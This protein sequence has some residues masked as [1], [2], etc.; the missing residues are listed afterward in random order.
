MAERLSAGRATI[1][2]HL[3]NAYRKLGARDRAAAAAEMMRR[4]L[5]E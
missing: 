2:T 1:K 5:I 3:E 4:G